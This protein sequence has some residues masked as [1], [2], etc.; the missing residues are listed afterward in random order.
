MGYYYNKNNYDTY[1]ISK[2]YSGNDVDNR[3][4]IEINNNESITID[5]RNV[6]FKS[7]EIG[8]NNVYLNKFIVDW[9]DGEITK[10][11]RK[12]NYDKSSLK[13]QND[14]SWKIVSHLFNNNKK[15]NYDDVSEEMLPR[16]IITLYNIF[17]N[18]T[19]ITIPY[20]V[21]YKTLYDIGS[22][23]EILSANVSNSN[24]GQ[25]VLK[26]NQ[27]GSTA[28]V[29]AKDWKKIYL[30]ETNEVD[31][32]DNIAKEYSD[33]WVLSDNILWDWKS[34][35][36]IHLSNV[37]YSNYNL[38]GNITAKNVPIDT[39]F[40]QCWKIKDS[41]NIRYKNDNHGDSID[42]FSI[43]CKNVSTDG[44]KN[45]NIQNT[46]EGVLLLK[47]Y[48]NG[49]NG[50]SGYCDNY[51]FATSES[52]VKKSYITYKSYNN[53]TYRF[54][55]ESGHQW[56]DYKTIT[57]TLK[58]KLWNAKNSVT[59]VNEQ[60][61]ANNNNIK[62][63]GVEGKDKWEEAD[64]TYQF[65]YDIK[66]NKGTVKIDPYA[67]PN[68]TYEVSFYVET[69]FG[70][71]Y[72]Y[73]KNWNREH[74]INIGSFNQITSYGVSSEKNNRT[75]KWKVVSNK[76]DKVLLDIYKKNESTGKYEEYKIIKKPYNNAS[77]LSVT[78]VSEKKNGATNTYYE[79]KYILNGN[80]T[81]NGDYY[82][83]VGAAVDMTR[84]VG[85]RKT[86]KPIGSA[87]TYKYNPPA[88]NITSSNVYPRWNGSTWVPYVRFALSGNDFSSCK[89]FTLHNG[90]KE[91]ILGNSQ[92]NSI[93]K[94]KILNIPLSQIPNFG[95]SKYT[96]CKISAYYKDDMYN[97]RGIG[98]GNAISWKSDIPSKYKNLPPY[99]KELINVKETYKEIV[100][101]ASEYKKYAGNKVINISAPDIYRQYKI[102]KKSDKKTYYISEKKN[103]YN[104]N[105][106]VYKPQEYED[107]SGNKYTRFVNFGSEIIKNGDV[108]V[109]KLPTATS[110]LSNK[111][112]YTKTY[113]KYSD[114][115]VL[116]LKCKNDKLDEVTNIMSANVNLYYNNSVGNIIDDIQ[117][118]EKCLASQD[119]RNKFS[120]E[121]T[122]LVPHKYKYEI[123]LSSLNTRNVG[124]G[125][126]DEY[127]CRNYLKEIDC[128][129][130]AKEA[131]SISCRLV[132][133]K[134]R[135]EFNIYHKQLK[136]LVLHYKIADGNEKTKEIETDWTNYQTSDGVAVD[137][138]VQ[139]W[140]TGDSDQIDYSSND[141]HIIC[142]I[143]S[144]VR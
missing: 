110:Y 2:L 38:S 10:S 24:L 124:N 99:T 122:G 125:E 43:D 90:D 85:F 55:L 76:Y 17:N 73:C 37:K 57:M 35:P 97:R 72:D 61:P 25:Y 4:V 96:Q 140:I 77:P 33:E 16:I 102:T 14:D 82:I 50:I 31:D 100:K 135:F 42:S 127:K 12:I 136:N 117:R 132:N 104:D 91:V 84:F 56:N 109:T 129:V 107:S 137:K 27:S 54:G 87:F 67:L 103:Y 15:L 45:A 121:F 32:I 19:V 130:P 83:R 131:T 71:K 68:G 88:V 13:Q 93:V 141:D 34:M 74:T 98:N 22:K 106:Y 101:G 81:P 44:Q 70:E 95:K 20:K 6:I 5:L 89:T 29:Q 1:V 52:Y 51:Y 94:S 105:F 78:K 65:V 7:E 113:D 75:I 48:V 40:C 66:S 11:S 36:K 108:D 64:Q 8:V 111:I 133:G 58:P 47:F 92:V 26:E 53:Y 114:T 142:E 9:G 120:P 18:K 112:T 3:D 118:K 49:A 39:W 119:V 79:Y 23:F 123:Q 28:I 46:S 62:H 60:I 139:Y 134:L 21:V 126:D 144:F 59:V 30:D 138:K 41:G 143:G 115:I 69:L 128:R 116:K 86:I 80:E 63:Y